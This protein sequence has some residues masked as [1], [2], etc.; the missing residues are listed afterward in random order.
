MENKNQSSKERRAIDNDNCLR[1]DDF[2]PYIGEFGFYQKRLVIY[3]I[4]FFFL[5]AFIYFTQIFLIIV[6]NDHWCR[7]P[8]LQDLSKDEQQ[9]LAIPKIKNNEYDNCLMYDTNYTKAIENNVTAADKSWPRKPCTDWCYDKEEVPYESI[10]TQYNW[11]C[12]NDHLAPWTVTVYFLGSIVGGLLFGYVADHWG[13]IPAV[14][15]SNFCGLIGGI[16]SAFC[17][18]FLWFS[19][20]RFVVGL[21]YDNCCMPIYVLSEF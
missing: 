17:S 13:R 20:T 21:A 6:P 1:F 11:V 10:A 14:M 16:L 9:K 3:A 18:S 7:I 15:L 5:W 12:K 8:E 2:L 19:I 4:P